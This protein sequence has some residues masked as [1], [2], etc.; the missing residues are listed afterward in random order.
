MICYNV[1]NIEE[2]YC[3]L[4]GLQISPASMT[5][6]CIH[7]IIISF[8]NQVLYFETEDNSLQEL[9]RNFKKLNE[10]DEIEITPYQYFKDFFDDS[11]L[12]IQER[13]PN[14]NNFQY[15]IFKNSNSIKKN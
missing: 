7:S 12:M 5:E 13:Y 9:T 1:K 6:M 15:V 10:R 4:C 3:P 2:I 14:R 8:T 11:F